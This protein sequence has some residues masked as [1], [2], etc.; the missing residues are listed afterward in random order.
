[1]LHSSP[2]FKDFHKWISVRSQQLIGQDTPRMAI[3]VYCSSGFELILWVSTM[4]RCLILA[5]TFFTH[6]VDISYFVVFSMSFFLPVLLKSCNF[7]LPLPRRHPAP[8]SISIGGRPTLLLVLDRIFF[9][10]QEVCS[11]SKDFS[12][13]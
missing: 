10:K 3:I 12:C 7:F 5:S 13:C 1:M 4:S 6:F 9:C 11:F 2:W 8:A